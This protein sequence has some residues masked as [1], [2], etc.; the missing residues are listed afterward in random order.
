[1]KTI[2]QAN[3][4]SFSLDFVMRTYF[5]DYSGHFFSCDTLRFFRSRVDRLAYMVDNN[6]FYFL[7]SEKKCF[8]DYR[9]TWSVRKIARNDQGGILI[10]TI[11]GFGAYET[12][13]Q[14]FRALRQ[15]L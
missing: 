3:I 2:K 7:T 10:E 14:A 4:G 1:M 9:R 6:T 8:S 11:G 13:A 5:P 15:L 12:K